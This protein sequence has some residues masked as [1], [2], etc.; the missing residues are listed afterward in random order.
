MKSFNQLISEIMTSAGGG[1]AGMHQ[2]VTPTDSLPQIAG[3]EADRLAIKPKRKKKDKLEEGPLHDLMDKHDDPLK[4][5]KAAA[6]AVKKKQ[7]N[8]K[9]R[10][11]ANTRELVALWYKRREREKQKLNTEDVNDNKFGTFGKKGSNERKDYEKNV[12]QHIFGK[13]K[14]PENDPRAIRWKP[15]TIP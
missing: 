2:S 15:P 6:I 11:A 4:F 5:A 12:I 7:L 8:L 14:D 10:G 9:T 13:S 3:R 1:I